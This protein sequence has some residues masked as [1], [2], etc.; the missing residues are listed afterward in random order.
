MD[1]LFKI[2]T[3]QGKTYS[4]NFNCKDDLKTFRSN[5]DIENKY[6][7]IYKGKAFIFSAPKMYSE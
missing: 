3:L 6:T 2:N 5:L 7:I 4:F 1:K